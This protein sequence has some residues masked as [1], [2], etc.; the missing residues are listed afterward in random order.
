M[1]LGPIF[2]PNDHNKFIW[3]NALTLLALLIIGLV[4]PFT[5][6]MV[7][8]LETL[9]IG[10]VHFFKMVYVGKYS[11]SQAHVLKPKPLSKGFFFLFHYSF[12]VAVQSIFVFA[13]F[14]FADK[15]IKEPF[16]LWVNYQHVLTFKGMGYALISICFFL[17]IQNYYSFFRN[18]LYHLYTVDRLFFQPYLRIF[19]QQFTVILAVFFIGIFDSGIM[20]AILLIALRLFVDLVGVFLGSSDKNKR[21]LARRLA[22]N[23]DQTEEEIHKELSNM[24]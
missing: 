3:L 24:F 11:A 7:Y 8:F 5:I 1:V 12:F 15:G 22:K 2:R 4:D 13:I 18:R 17:F 16:N 6:V 14:Q 9:A 10:L 20:A 19:V 21:N 23:S